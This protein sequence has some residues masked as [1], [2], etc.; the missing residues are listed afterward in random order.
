MNI[1]EQISRLW[2]GLIFAILSSVAI[3]AQAND[4]Y[5]SE[6][7]EGQPYYDRYLEIY[8]GVILFN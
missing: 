1:R 4:I 3:Q 5:F 7:A 8:N 2:V 6:Y